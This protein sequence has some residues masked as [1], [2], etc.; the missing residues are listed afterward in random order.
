[1]PIS[2]HNLVGAQVL[3]A[4]L[5]GTEVFYRSPL[6]QTP[7]VRG[8]VPVLFPQFNDIGPLVKHGLVRALP[9]NRLDIP[10]NLE[11]NTTTLQYG[12]NILA[13]DHPSWPH[14]A[15]LTLSVWETAQTL[16][17]ALKIL[18][19]GSDSF[20]WT[21]GLHPYFAVHDLLKSH[22]QGLSGLGVKDKFDMDMH[23]QP[24]GKLSWTDQPFERLIDGCPALILYDGVRTLR[25]SATG[26]DQWMVWNPGRSGGDALKDLPAGDWQ[27]FVCIEPVCMTRPVSL[28]PGDLF[29][30]SLSIE[31]IG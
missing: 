5:Q 13:G 14:A 10:K 6:S 2:L 27:R 11:S 20:S 17:F 9:W 12:L 29:N 3:E 16:E 15:Q 25:L 31:Y 30:G 19:V 7:P 28:Q 24:K 1:M 8:G 18:N 26:F 21:G 23:T 4:Q 22:V